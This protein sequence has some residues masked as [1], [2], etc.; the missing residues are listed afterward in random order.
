MKSSIVICYYIN[1]L[2]YLLTYWFH[3]DYELFDCLL[4]NLLFLS[5]SELGY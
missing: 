2:T 3:A 1:E 5:L 4:P